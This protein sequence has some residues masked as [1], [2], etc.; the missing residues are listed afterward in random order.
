MNLNKKLVQSANR[1]YDG[2]AVNDFASFI[3]SDFKNDVLLDLSPKRAEENINQSNG[4]IS[5]MELL[6]HKNLTDDEISITKSLVD[7]ADYIKSSSSFY[8]FKFNV[9]HNTCPLKYVIKRLETFPIE[10]KYDLERYLKL[11]SQMPEIIEGMREKLN[12]QYEIGLSIHDEELNISKAMFLTFLQKE[13][14][15]LNPINRGIN[16]NE[17]NRRE[18]ETIIQRIN[19]EIHKM[20]E[21]FDSY[22]GREFANLY[23]LKN[24]EEYYQSLIK[25]YTSYDL[26]PQKIHEIGI[27]EL[28]NTKSKIRE[29]MRQMG[30]Y[31]SLEDFHKKMLSNQRFFDKTPE[32]L[33][34]RFNRC[35]EKIKPKLSLAFSIKPQADCISKALPHEQE[36]STSWGYY[37]VPIGTENRGI[38]Y[39]SAAELSTRSQIRT[40][41]ITYHE[42][43]PGHHFQV[44]LAREDKTLP[45]ISQ[46]H[47]NTAFAD[48]WAEYTTDLANELGMYDEF[49]LY[50]RYIW[51]MVLCVRLVVDT[52][53]NALGW[54]IN[55][56]RRFMAENT[57]LS[58]YEIKME[59]L[60]Y[61]VDMPGQALAYKIGSLKNH[62]LRNLAQSKLKEKFDIKH[63]HDEVLKYGSIP[64]YLLDENIRRYIDRE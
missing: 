45:N 41:A 7:F 1:Y 57:I 26:T 35:L 9:T 18:I 55:K 29:L 33:A 62:E 37:S 58:E 17:F 48:G 14:S 27:L 54:D 31:M 22:I 38:F 49:D 13:N 16:L 23:K 21:C 30:F 56:M 64:L 40:A 60:R 53:I 63:Y 10:N 3:I 32:E 20:I 2:I 24:G 50:G 19:S 39:F 52:G 6:K 28:E 59:S 5:E 34:S 51:D 11:V 43:L 15:R 4:F 46:H 8:M 61:A 12:K 47:F 44:N 25:T 42:L 36:G